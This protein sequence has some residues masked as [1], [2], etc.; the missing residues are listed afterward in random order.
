MAGNASVHRCSDPTVLTNDPLEAT[1]TKW[2]TWSGFAHERL[3]ME[4]VIAARILSEPSIEVIF[5]KDKI[6]VSYDK[7]DNFYENV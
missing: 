2:S 7:C 6:N 1:P 3:K 5:A 4:H